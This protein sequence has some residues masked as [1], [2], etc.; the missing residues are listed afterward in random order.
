MS[1]PQP[2][3]FSAGIVVVRR[4]GNTWRWLLLRAYRNWDFPKGLAQPG[5]APMR[6]ALRETEEETGLSDLAFP[7]GE[8]YRE[9]APYSGG[10][11][12]RYYL[13]E[14]DR[15]DIVLPVSAELGRPEH[16]EWRWVNAGA[17]ARLLPPRLQP[18][19]AWARE[20]V[21]KPSPP[22]QGLPR[23]RSGGEAGMPYPTP[24]RKTK[25][26]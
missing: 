2:A 1:N 24:P 15:K 23:T 22:S 19:L 12:A 5:E 13:G 8:V 4:E 7:W 14:T 21:D 11:V 17:A 26:Q 18:I 3:R 20:I 25:G 6:T 16:D 9:T 10:K